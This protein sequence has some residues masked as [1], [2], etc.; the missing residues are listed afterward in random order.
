MTFTVIFNKCEFKADTKVNAPNCVHKRRFLKLI[1]GIN[2]M[3]AYFV[4]YISAVTSGGAGEHVF[5][6]PY[7]Q[8]KNSR[9]ILPKALRNVYLFWLLIVD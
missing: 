4:I 7:L 3:C 1:V 6:V 5:F 9:T 8:L 2:G